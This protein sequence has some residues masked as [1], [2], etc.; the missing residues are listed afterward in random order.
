MSGDGGRIAAIV[1]RECEL[2]AQI[3]AI[4]AGLEA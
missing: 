3:G 1:A 4:A 2:R